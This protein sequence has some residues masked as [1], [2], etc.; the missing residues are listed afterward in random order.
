MTIY[1]F[2]ESRARQT[3]A[4]DFRDST[5]RSPSCCMQGQ[6]LNK[7]YEWIQLSLAM[8]KLLLATEHDRG[9]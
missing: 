2:F 5:N 8:Y 1:H 3:G 9:Q 4:R 6:N 7:I